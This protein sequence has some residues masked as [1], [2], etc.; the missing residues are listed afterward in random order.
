MPWNF[1]P[2]AMENNGKTLTEGDA[3]HCTNM[4]K[5]VIV[6]EQCELMCMRIHI[7]IYVVSGHLVSI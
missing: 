4:S 5:F 1:I 6:I 7:T 2:D 3:Y